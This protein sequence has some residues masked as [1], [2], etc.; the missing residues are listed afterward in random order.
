MTGMISKQDF[1][2]LVANTTKYLQ[3]HSMQIAKLNRVIADLEARLKHIE[4]RKK[5]GPKPKVKAA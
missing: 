5:P 1:D 3:E 4:E 2:Q